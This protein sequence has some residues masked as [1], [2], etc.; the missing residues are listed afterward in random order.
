MWH[1]HKVAEGGWYGGG[2]E[3]AATIADAGFSG[4]PEYVSRLSRQSAVVMATTVGGKT[5]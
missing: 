5:R 1:L 2:L 4:D 3:A